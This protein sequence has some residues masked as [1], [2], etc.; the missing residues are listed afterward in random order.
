MRHG[1]NEVRLQALH[2]ITFGT[3]RF[4]AGGDQSG[5]ALYTNGC[6]IQQN[7]ACWILQPLKTVLLTSSASCKFVF[8]LP[9]ADTSSYLGG[10][11][12]PHMGGL[13]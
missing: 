5:M 10:S 11:P 2:K 7:M 9:G 1:E 8:W 6:H 13:L 4:E 3:Q 12:M